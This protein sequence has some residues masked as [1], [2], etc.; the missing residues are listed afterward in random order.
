MLTLWSLCS[1]F[2]QL[3]AGFHESYVISGS[4][5][6]SDGGNLDGTYS[7]IEAHC[8]NGPDC[9]VCDYCDGCGAYCDAGS[10]TTCGNAPVFQKGGPGGDVLYRTQTYARYPF[11][12]DSW[13]TVGPSSVLAS[14]Y[15][16]F[17]GCLAAA[18]DGAG[19]EGAAQAEG[20]E[21]VEHGDARGL[22]RESR[23]GRCRRAREEEE[24]GAPRAEERP[25]RRS[26][27]ERGRG[28]ELNTAKLEI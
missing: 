27:G 23:P 13:W 11:P 4:S 17:T 21:A 18:R 25:E 2:V 3:P 7:L 28:G 10:P 26:A 20:E 5:G 24:E 6:A 8:S 14:C 16:P 9:H 15:G 1:C 22:G 19:R 12:A